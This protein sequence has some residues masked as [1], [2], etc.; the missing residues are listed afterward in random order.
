VARC[1]LCGR[2]FC[3]ECVVE[4]E[5]RLICAGCLREGAGGESERRGNWWG[6]LVVAGQWGCSLA[7]LW[8]LFY[9]VA[10]VLR[11]IPSDIHDGL[12]WNL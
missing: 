5:G 12:I 10:L 8:L 6:W 4:H 2:S 9:G 11:R 3:R 1:R 7:G